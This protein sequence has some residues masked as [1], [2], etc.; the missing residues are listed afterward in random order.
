MKINQ[1]ADKV[2]EHMDDARRRVRLALSK[3]R[4]D[5]HRRADLA[6]ERG[7]VIEHRVFS[8]AANEVVSLLQ[9]A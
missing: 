1:D 3:L 8:M 7:D 5:Y 4:R 9:K 2:G 6:W